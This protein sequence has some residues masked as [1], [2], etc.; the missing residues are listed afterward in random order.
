MD[1]LNPLRNRSIKA[2]KA[3]T[4]YRPDI[5][6]GA[7]CPTFQY[8]VSP[9]P[10][11]LAMGGLLSVLAVF[12]GF[13]SGPV[14][15]LWI[16]GLDWIV[17]LGFIACTI[18]RQARARAAGANTEIGCLCDLCA[19]RLSITMWK[20]RAEVADWPWDHPIDA[21]L[22]RAA[23]RLG[24]VAP[25]SGPMLVAILRNGTRNETQCCAM[26]SIWAATLLELTV[27]AD[28]VR[29]W[30]AEQAGVLVALAQVAG[31]PYVVVPDT[32]ITCE[33]YAR[34]RSQG[35]YSALSLV[36]A[37]LTEPVTY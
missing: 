27:S 10:L 9:W 6:G 13:T 12:I 1:I 32:D 20:R 24:K 15:G 4:E 3:Q 25:M 36:A 11:P 33:L 34:Y 8:V 2:S 23:Q 16:A 29:S 30:P 21:M 14:I 18:W 19:Q 7:L 31:I 26:A 5:D 17:V 35:G 22:T 37:V 28:L